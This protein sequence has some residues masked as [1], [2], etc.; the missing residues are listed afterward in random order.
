ME[1]SIHMETAALLVI[2]IL[3]LFH[4]DKKTGHN[5]RY[6]LFS[7][8]LAA[9]ELTIFVDM[10]S[11]LAITY[12]D[13]VPFWL[14]YALAALYFLTITFTFSAMAYYAFYIIFEH[15]ADKHCLLRAKRIIGLLGS[16]MVVLSIAN[17][18]TGCLFSFRGNEYVRGPLNRTGYVILL[19]ELGMLVKCY[20]RNRLVVSRSVRRVIYMLP[21][22]VLLMTL[23]QQTSP[24]FLMNGTLAALTNL[25]LFTSFQSSRIGQDPQT[26]LQ[27]RS[28]F[29]EELSFLQKKRSQFHI[30]LICLERYEAVNQKFGVTRG[31]TFMYMI[32]RYLE[33][34]SAHYK[35]FRFGNT[36]FILLGSYTGEEDAIKNARLVQE[37][38]NEPWY[39]ENAECILEARFADIVCSGGEQKE[40]QII[41]QLEY[42]LQCAR[43]S[44][45]RRLVHF[46]E[47]LSSQ[48][49][50]KNRILDLIKDALINDRFQLYYQPIYDC[51]K[52]QFCSAESLLRLFDETGIPISPSEFIPL[53]EENG[54]IDAISWTVLKKVCRFWG[55]HPNLSLNSI[56]INMSMQQLEDR[57]L[58]EHVFECLKYYK[59]PADKVKIEITERVIAE[60]LDLVHSVMT[61]LIGKDIQFCLDD[62][63]IGYS[64]FASVIALPFETIKLDYSLL[65]GID[66]D[67]E[68]SDRIR[69]LVQMLHRSGHVVVAEG[70][71]TEP[72]MRAARDLKIDRI[73][74]YYYAKPMPEDEFLAFL[75]RSLSRAVS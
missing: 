45:D 46:D 64:N 31:D 39:A 28:S 71:E 22:L 51:A 67:E 68:V 26:E 17:F 34:F 50:R 5:L 53:A 42:A 65:A 55:E 36:Q 4:Y 30:I 32:A 74:G 24:D 43:S 37:R 8:C 13:K 15:A 56:A 3:A 14:N 60:E 73:Q 21:P 75:Q 58:D 38:F 2:A 33:H 27:N 69:L 48:L 40:S 72:Q 19:I 63:G 66:S 41:A 11:A 7:V 23:L 12:S 16:I 57:H 62:F 20:L 1:L 9:S 47:G 61:R 52:G 54:L 25:I 35:A 59:V 6:R 49:K 70:I 18:W 44:S 10:A 29:F